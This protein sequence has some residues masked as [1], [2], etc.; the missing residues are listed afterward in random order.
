MTAKELHRKQMEAYPFVYG[1]E[2][3]AERFIKEFTDFL[4]QNKPECEIIDIYFDYLISQ[5]LCE[6]EE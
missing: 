3:L 4:N 5:G 2:E 6:V 1:S